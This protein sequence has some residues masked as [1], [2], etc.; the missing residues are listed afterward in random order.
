[1]SEWAALISDVRAHLSA[2]DNTGCDVPLFRGHSGNWPLVCGLGRPAPDKRHHPLESVLY[3]DFVSLAGPLLLR[4]DSS[5]DVLF[6]MQHH[7]LP[8]RLL[9]WSGTFA[10]AVHF[11]LK[12]YIDCKATGAPL[13]SE[14]APSVWV[15]DPFALNGKTSGH[16][17]VLN[18]ELDLEGSYKEFFIDD[19]KELTETALAVNPTHHGRRIAAQRGYFTLHSDVF[20]P[21]DKLAPEC[22]RKFDIPPGAVGEG[23]DFLALAGASEFSLFPDLDGLARHLKVRH[24][25]WM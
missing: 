1:V 25:N 16:E 10:V 7:G 3:Y 21:L 8:T 19:E 15:L 24:A 4:P 22:L 20:T 14:L 11:A 2:L 18:P 9:D 23:L 17:G 13:S 5:W 12:P 6:T